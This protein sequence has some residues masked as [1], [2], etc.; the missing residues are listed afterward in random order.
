MGSC[1][2]HVHVFIQRRKLGFQFGQYI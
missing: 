2:A 1:Y